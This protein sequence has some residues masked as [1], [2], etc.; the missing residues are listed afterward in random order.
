MLKD[1]HINMELAKGSKSEY[2][3]RDRLGITIGRI[4]I[5]YISTENKYCHSKIKFYRDDSQGIIY[6]KEA[7]KIFI[8]HLFRDKKIYKVNI[9][10][11]EDICTRPFID[12]G[13]ILEGIIM[14]SIYYNNLRK[15][16]IL[17]GINYNIYGNLNTTN[18]LRIKS[19]NINLKI[20]TPDDSMDLL[21]YYIKNK[22]HLEP[23]EPKREDS[24]YSIESQHQVLMENYK[25]FISGT[26]ACFGVYKDKTFIGKIQISGI[27]YGIFKS[28]IVGYSIDKEYQGKGYMK[29]ALGKIIEYAFNEM[30]LHRLEASTLIDNKRSQFL[31]KS[32]GFKEI[33]INEK[34]LFIDGQWKDHIT[35]YKI[36]NK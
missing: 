8:E 35:F 17:F 29:E 34:Y 36:K 11:D 30:N 16:E 3:I 21:H 6:L 12:L 23:Y 20:L 10:A 14:D 5:I 2:I 15:S 24:F 33:G 9:S 19:N 22:K 13:F 18:I 27:I 26:A 28:G 25:Q 7:I 32:C 31:L 4:N 1:I